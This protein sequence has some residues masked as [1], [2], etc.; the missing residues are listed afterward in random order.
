M[1]ALK[2]LRLAAD[3]PS[4]EALKRHQ[5]LSQITVNAG[6]LRIRDCGLT[7]DQAW[8]WEELEL[9]DDLG[10]GAASAADNYQPATLR[11]ELIER[12]PFP[13][14][15]A[16][17]IGLSVCG[18][19]NTLH[20]QGLIHRDVKPANIFRVG[21]KVVLGDYGL[22]APPGQ[23]FDFNGTE[24][25]LPGEGATDAAADLFAL[26]KTL[27]ELWTGCDRLEF[28][29]LPERILDDP[30]WP[31]R[32]AALNEL[33]LRLCAHRAEGRHRSADKLAAALQ[34]I[35]SGRTRHITRRQW[36]AVAGGG[37]LAAGVTAAGIWIVRKPPVA[38]WWLKKAWSNI[39]VEWDEK[40]PILDE[41]RNCLFHLQCRHRENVLGRL[42]LAS[43]GYRK[44]PVQGVTENPFTPILHPKE[45]TIWFAEDGLGPVW[46]LD[47]DTGE[48]SRLP[49]GKVPPEIADRSF[50]SHAYWNPVTNRLGSFG[51]YGCFEVHNWRWEFDA[52]KGEWLCVERNQPGREPCCRHGGRF[53]PVGDGRRLLLIGG[54]GNLSGKQGERD[55]GLPL[56]DGR[57]HALGDLWS[58][59]LASNRWTCLVHTPG[60][61]LPNLWSACYLPALEK[62][63]VMH[64]RSNS[65]PFG[66]PAE[67]SIHRLGRDRGFVR[68]SSRGDVPDGVSPGYA[69]AMPSG[70]TLLAFQKRGVF[71]V[72]LES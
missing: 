49:G 20:S 54:G 38:C 48:F 45:R 31:K 58:L 33:L 42:D 3:V 23:P 18:A 30:S 67:V 71:E 52:A 19:L 51:G 12:G 9:A 6:L 50:Y 59:D 56:F 10:G 39:P 68:I 25:F 47:P 35:A 72:A 27:Y 37:S 24:G 21:G 5:R 46:R 11:A 44:I 62:V 60:L 63:T 15:A 29:T 14:E 2:L 13:T 41:Q 65:A 1:V 40:L 53:L 57:F 4:D 64:A 7:A 70:R 55:P 36:L 26:G 32:G 61:K 28:P 22:V 66:D 43:Y 16:L 34:A 17:S 69:T 8:L